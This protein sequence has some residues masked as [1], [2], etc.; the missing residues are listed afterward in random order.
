VT[1]G[2]TVAATFA[3]PVPDLTGKT[4]EQAKSLLTAVGLE[5]VPSPDNPGSATVVTSQDP[6]GGPGSVTPPDLKVRATF[7]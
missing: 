5:L 6:K 7:G 2:T 3:G 1:A 4:T